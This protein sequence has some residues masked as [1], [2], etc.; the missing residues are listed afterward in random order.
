MI[1]LGGFQQCLCIVDVQAMVTV[2]NRVSYRQLQCLCV[3]HASNV[4]Y[5]V[6][7]LLIVIHDHRASPCSLRMQ[8]CCDRVLA[9]AM[10]EDAAA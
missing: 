6:L 4:H 9:S 7:Q 5:W 1:G 2:H 3:D 10:S 8:A